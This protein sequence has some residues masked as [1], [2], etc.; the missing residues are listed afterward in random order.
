[1]SQSKLFSIGKPNASHKILEELT[2]SPTLR[3]RINTCTQGSCSGSGNVGGRYVL[4][5]PTVSLRKKHNPAFALACHL[6]NHLNL[7]C[8]VLY[9]ILDDDSLP[10]LKKNNNNN[11]NN[12]SFFSPICM[13]SRRL[14]FLTEAISETG[15]EWS[16]H[17]AGVAIRV[18][19]PSCRNPDYLTL[20]HGAGVVVMDEPF[21]HPFVSLVRRVELACRKSNTTCVR[22]DGS[23]TVPPVSIL[24]QKT[25]VG[26]E[27]GKGG[28]NVEYKGVPTKA[29]AW[30][31]KTEKFRRDQ[32]TNVVEKGAFDAPELMIRVEEEDFF[33]NTT[34]CGDD[35]EAKNDEMAFD[36]TN[37]DKEEDTSRIKAIHY[38]DFPPL[39]QNRDTPAPGKRPWTISELNDLVLSGPNAI[40]EWSLS[41]PGADPTVPPCTQTVGTSSAG[42]IR[43][44]SWVRDRKGLT[45]YARKR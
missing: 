26:G 34:K 15:P 17:G 22:V 44:N 21:V 13:T 7:P 38:T 23:T 42:I 33:L 40:K 19:G 29:W 31:K 36:C 4:Y 35:C 24:D 43:W 25:S 12:T 37:D 8:L 3:S 14:A 27:G 45:N 6:A 41:W 18:H 10:L 16:K 30:Q 1:M 32:I 28:G 39:W 20:T 5:L 2:I 9:T 11:I